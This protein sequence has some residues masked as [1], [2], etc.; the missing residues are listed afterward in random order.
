MCF[1]GKVYQT[2]G[3]LKES[4]SEGFNTKLGIES[5]IKSTTSVSCA[6]NMANTMDAATRRDDG[7]PGPRVAGDDG[8]HDGKTKEK[9]QIDVTDGGEEKTVDEGGDEIMKSDTAEGAPGDGES[10][11]NTVATKDGDE[12]IDSD[13]GHM[14]GETGSG[15]AG[16]RRQREEGR[17]STFGSGRQKEQARRGHVNQTTTESEPGRRDVSAT[18]GPDSLAQSTV[19]GDVTVGATAQGDVDNGE[20]EKSEPVPVLTLEEAFEQLKQ[21]MLAAEQ[22]PPGC[23][24]YA[25][26]EDLFTRTYNTTQIREKP[27]KAD[28]GYPELSADEAQELLELFRRVVVQNKRPITTWKRTVADLSRDLHR[29]SWTVT[30]LIKKYVDQAR[31]D[32]APTVGAWG[33]QRQQGPS[34]PTDDEPPAFSFLDSTATIKRQQEIIKY[35]TRP[36][37]YPTELREATELEWEIMLGLLEGT[38]IAKYLPQFLRRVCDADNLL[39]FQNTIVAQVEGELVGQL[40]DSTPMYRDHQSSSRLV[41]AVMQAVRHRGGDVEHIYQMMKALKAAAYNPATHA[42][43]FFF[44]N[45]EAASKWDGLALPFRTQLIRLV[46]VNAVLRGQ[47]KPK[48]V[49]DRQLGTDGL[50]NAVTHSR[51]RVHLLN[52]SRFV[53]MHQLT[54]FLRQEFG[55]QFYAYS[56]DSYGPRSSKSLMWE[57]LFDATICPAKLVDIFRIHWMGH[58]ILVH[59]VSRQRQQPCLG[60]GKPGHQARFCKTTDA[61]LH[62][63]NC[64]TASEVSTKTLKCSPPTFRS[65]DEMREAFKVSLTFKKKEAEEPEPKQQQQSKHQEDEK[66]EKPNTKN[67]QA[68]GDQQ[69]SDQWKKQGNKKNGK[70]KQS[71]LNV[72]PT[73]TGAQREG[74]SDEENQEVKKSLVVEGEHEEQRQEDD[75]Q[76]VHQQQHDKEEIK[77]AKSMLK[78]RS[79]MSK[80]RQAEA[81]IAKD[82]NQFTNQ[83]M[84]GEAVSLSDI[85]EAIG[86][87]ESKTPATGNCQY[88][89]MAEAAFQVPFQRTSNPVKLETAAAALKKAI[90]A[91]AMLHFGADFPQRGQKDFLTKRDRFG[92]GM[93]NKEMKNE[94]VQFYKD[95]AKSASGRLAIIPRSVWGGPETLRMAAKALNATIFLAVDNKMLKQ[96]TYTMYKPNSK[97]IDAAL[98][99]TATEFFCTRDEWAAELVVQRDVAVA[100]GEPLPMVLKYGQ[101]HYSS[102]LFTRANEKAPK[103]PQN[104][105]LKAALRPRTQSG[106]VKAD[107]EKKQR[108]PEAGQQDE[109]QHK[110]NVNG[111]RNRRGGDEEQGDVQQQR[112]DGEKSGGNE[113]Q[114]GAPV[115]TENEEKHADEGHGSHLWTADDWSGTTEDFIDALD[116]PTVA[117]NVKLQLSQNIEH[118]SDRKKEIVAF[119]ETGVEHLSEAEVKYLRTMDLD[120]DPTTEEWM[121][122]YQVPG[123]VLQQWQRQVQA[124]RPD[125][126]EGSHLGSSAGSEGVPETP[127][128]PQ[129]KR[130]RQTTPI[131]KRTRGLT[132]INT[133]NTAVALKKSKAMTR[134][135]AAASTTFDRKSQDKRIKEQW[136]GWSTDWEKTCKVDFPSIHAGPAAW[137][138]AILADWPKIIKMLRKSTGP[139]VVLNYVKWPVMIALTKGLR[140]LAIIRGIETIR[141]NAS[142]AGIKDWLKSW[143]KRINQSA[144]AMLKSEAVE[145]RDDWN[146]LRQYAYGDD[147]LL[148]VCAIQF[149]EKLCRRL[150]CGILYQEEIRMMAAPEYEE[151]THPYD[152]VR[153]LA[154]ALRRSTELAAA[155]KLGDTSGD[156]EALAAFFASVGDEAAAED[157]D[158]FDY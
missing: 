96:F 59:H 16:A 113:Q 24:W 79:T 66:N 127:R 63:K 18:S 14:G 65:I 22:P 50:Q 81:D 129:G 42:L 115:T 78:F 80:D 25:R 72:Q 125:D 143:L 134:P 94:I 23:D 43:H 132:V 48:T 149:K 62:T 128:K 102:L 147:P 21:L 11:S 61:D 41:E 53:E 47:D 15:D 44:Y 155:M 49:W 144:N 83:S 2:S 95:I 111:D 5:S 35:C 137:T 150:L 139:Q 17:A 91:A 98:I 70:K 99:N 109:Q 92:K 138:K 82:L 27:Q 118:G 30:A 77:W 29:S 157:S 122:R 68:A 108:V 140:E 131:D 20:Q 119:M 136:E 39:R 101:D 142:D 32:P 154:L 19:S 116:D 67:G 145:S 74:E 38:L 51:Y 26:V 73:L 133:N 3:L 12:T 151:A 60:C 100:G 90:Q 105:S 6:A 56:M 34:Q 8:R 31:L 106:R 153:A 45:R 126:S 156:F 57:L 114:G 141:D 54:A 103:P 69:N 158:T 40:N 75:K 58:L 124:W 64:I 36:F 121:R 71:K 120:H 148:K 52:V 112:N 46:D 13:A 84:S 87:V 10:G 28:G 76:S 97:K 37:E 4:E 85:M 110:A 33:A 130:D 123:G 89:A 135:E 88:Y 104:S 7:D 86:L 152:L 107:M 1:D 55:A 146:R 93:T 9:V 117:H